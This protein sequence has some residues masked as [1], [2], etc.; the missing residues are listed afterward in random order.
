MTKIFE[1]EDYSIY[2][3]EQLNYFAWSSGEYKRIKDS[4]AEMLATKYLKQIKLPH[5]RISVRVFLTQNVMY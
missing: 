2:R 4:R 1:T 3:D 5:D